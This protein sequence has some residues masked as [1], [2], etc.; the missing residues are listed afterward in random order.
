MSARGG[1]PLARI[2]LEGT[3]AA[4][5]QLAADITVRIVEQRVLPIGGRPWK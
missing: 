1:A 3:N 4:K 2:A 5:R